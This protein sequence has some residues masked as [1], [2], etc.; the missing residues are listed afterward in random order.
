MGKI[1]ELYKIIF[2]FLK[3]LNRT[4]FSADIQIHTAK[5]IK[6]MISFKRLN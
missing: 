1:S 2:T 5:N 6:F 4:N 3:I